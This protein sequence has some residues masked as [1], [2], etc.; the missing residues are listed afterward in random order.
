MLNAPKMV[1]GLLFVAAVGW[2][3]AVG[4]FVAAGHA[5][6]KIDAPATVLGLGIFT[7]LPALL[8]FAFGV[9]AWRMGRV[10]GR[11]LADIALER[12]VLERLSARGEV[13]LP[14]LAAELHVSVDAVRDAVYRLAG[15]NLLVGYV[16]WKEQKLYSREAEAL[17][18]AG[19]CPR[20]GGKL[21]L[22]GKGVIRCAYCGS[23]V[24]L[25]TT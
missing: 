25:P 1:G 19:T 23:E 18:R 2:L 12:S 13:F 11:Q 14:Q 8:L 5:A 22:A 10:L 6:G 3:V 9:V 20:C 16:N 15:K 17:N 24:F 21:E 4:T 7:F